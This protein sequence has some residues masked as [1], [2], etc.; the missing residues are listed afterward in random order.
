MER[1]RVLW[2]CVQPSIVVMKSMTWRFVDGVNAERRTEIDLKVLNVCHFKK[3]SRHCFWK[4]SCWWYSLDRI[5][6]FQQIC[7][8]S[9]AWKA[10][11]TTRAVSASLSWP[12]DSCP[13]LSD[14]KNPATCTEIRAA[15]PRSDVA[16]HILKQIPY[17]KKIAIHSTE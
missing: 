2:L 7:I 15:F 1:A 17:L 10:G 14:G 8:W 11:S 9:I 13:P 12:C 3:N 5:W 6:C 16:F 4:K